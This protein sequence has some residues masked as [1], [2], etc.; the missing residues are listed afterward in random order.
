MLG[1]LNSVEIDEVIQHQVI[2]RLGCH[3]DGITYVVPVSYAYDGEYVYVHSGEGLKME[4][5]RKNPKVCFQ[6]DQFFNMANWRCVVAWGEFEELHDKKDRDF[7]LQKLMGRIL[8]F[9]SSETTH[10]TPHWPFPTTD[11]ES[12]EGIVFRI[13]LE[14]K[15]GR[16]EKSIPASVFAT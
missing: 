15:T 3:A 14:K 10:L 7:A 11:L 8:P 5:M 16:F 12:I 6:I 9:A 2:G 1:K 4:M 13:K